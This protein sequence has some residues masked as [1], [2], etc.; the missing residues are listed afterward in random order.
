[1]RILAFVVVLLGSF[2][3]WA[4]GTTTG[5]HFTARLVAESRSPAPGKHLTMALVINPERGWHIY[6]KN[7]GESG[8]PPRARW[9]LPAGFS[10]GELKHPVPTQQLVDGM[11][12]NIHEHRVVLLTDLSVPD[13]V[14]PGTP[15]PIGLNVRLAICNVGHCIPHTLSLSR[16]LVA[17]D[18]TPDPRQAL[19]FHRARAALPLPVKKPGKYTLSAAGLSLLLPLPASGE[20]SSAQVFFD[21]D[22]VVAH[23]VQ[24]VSTGKGRISITM[25]RKGIPVGAS[26]SGVVRVVRS[27]QAGRHSI[28]GYRF[29][30]MPAAAAPAAHG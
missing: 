2:P 4:A 28:E 27:G 10:A 13:T 22:G 25:S 6:W 1:M 24:R 30:A 17:G 16:H 29:T 3:V 8:L 15:V 12:S 5:P 14:T 21:G 23:G 20:I 18:G 26:L 11:I 7:P 19:L 9:R